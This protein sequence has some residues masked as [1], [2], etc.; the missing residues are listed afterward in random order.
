MESRFSISNEVTAPEMGIYQS[1]SIEWIYICQ[2]P[3]IQS[4]WF[5]RNEINVRYW[6]DSVRQLWFR[7]EIF[8]ILVDLKTL[9]KQIDNHFV[10]NVHIQRYDSELNLTFFGFIT[11]LRL[12]QPRIF[13]CQIRT[14]ADQIITKKKTEQIKIRKCSW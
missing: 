9:T 12:K 2:Q 5:P 10:V 14:V 3:V 7:V 11:F 13:S 1:F 4:L 6:L 8:N